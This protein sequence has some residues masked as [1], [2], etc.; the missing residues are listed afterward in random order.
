MKTIAISM[1]LDGLPVKLDLPKVSSEIDT[2]M[3]GDGTTGFLGKAIA[4]QDGVPL[5]MLFAYEDDS[6]P[7]AD[8]AIDLVK[9]IVGQVAVAYGGWSFWD[10]FRREFGISEFLEEDHPNLYSQ[11]VA[12]LKL[13]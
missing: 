5:A 1:I 4:A 12:N 3:R 8:V 11:L 7:N 2:C 9:H 13:A 10:S 6:E